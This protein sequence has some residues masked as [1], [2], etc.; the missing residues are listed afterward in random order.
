MHHHKGYLDQSFHPI[1]FDQGA[2][3]ARHS[4][5]ASSPCSVPSVQALAPYPA[6]RA[7]A[8]LMREIVGASL[9][10]P[11]LGDSVTSPRLAES[12]P[13]QGRIDALA[14][15]GWYTELQRGVGASIFVCTPTIAERSLAEKS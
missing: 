13:H 4:G 2:V 1:S 10:C 6:C 8:S 3:W 14:V 15:Y 12:L 11:R 5:G 7:C 9:R